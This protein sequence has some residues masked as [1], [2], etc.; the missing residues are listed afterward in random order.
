MGQRDMLP[1]KQEG[2][3]FDGKSVAITGATGGIG[4]AVAEMFIAGGAKV[5]ISDLTCPSKTAD[6]IGAVAFKCDVSEEPQ[7]DE[8]IDNASAANGPVDIFVANA[9]VG[10]GDEKHAAGASNEAWD[11][12]W[13]INVMQSVWAARTLLPQ[14]RERGGGRLIVTASAAGLMGQIGSASYTA[15]KHAVEAFA[16]QVAFEHAHQ[17]VKVNCICPQYVRTN[18]TK[19]F[20]MAESSPDGFLEPSDVANALKLAIEEDRFLVL[21]HAVVGEYFKHRASNVDAYI[22][23][24]AKLKSKLKA[25]T[26][27]LKS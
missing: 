12:S 14:W 25:E 26:L 19:G 3:M 1:K 16:E 27:P 22:A 4:R 6:A 20:A 15:T 10:Y 18:M 24:M 5:A 7:I 21:P 13:K 23:G 17:G 9:G 2:E 8:F 11:A